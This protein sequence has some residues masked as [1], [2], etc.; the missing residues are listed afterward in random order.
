MS[1]IQVCLSG[2]ISQCLQRATRATCQTL[3]L[4]NCFTSNHSKHTVN[5]SRIIA[6]VK[7]YRQF[8]FCQ[9][10]YIQLSI[11]TLHELESKSSELYP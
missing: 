10:E 6:H 3:V 5:L 4:S 9:L 7:L 2:L 11:Q 8:C 1:L